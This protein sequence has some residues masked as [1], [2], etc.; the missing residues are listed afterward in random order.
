MT[1][2]RVIR[3]GDSKPQPRQPVRTQ[4]LVPSAPDAERALIGSLLIEG[5]SA[6]AVDECARMVDHTSFLQPAW[7]CAWR[8]IWRRVLGGMGDHRRPVRRA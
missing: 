1:T 2:T 5:A 8:S 6:L 7:A 4:P 3:R